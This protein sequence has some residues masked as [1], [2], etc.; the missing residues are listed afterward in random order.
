MG[1]GYLKHASLRRGAGPWGIVGLYAQ[2]DLTAAKLE[3]HIAHE[4]SR[5]DVRFA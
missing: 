5:Q 3:A 4:R 2:E 1:D